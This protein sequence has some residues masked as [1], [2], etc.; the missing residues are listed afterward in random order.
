MNR[1]ILVVMLVGV[2]VMGMCLHLRARTGVGIIV[3]EPTGL[4]IKIGHFPVIGIAW[5]WDDY[6]HLHIDYWLKSARLDRSL[7]WFFG[8]GAK[9][10][11]H[12]KNQGD[13]G[14]VGLGLRVPLGLSY[15]FSRRFEVFGEVAPG[16]KLI[17]G[18]EFDIDGGIGIRF[19]F[20]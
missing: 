11:V 9:V 17:P 6:F 19:Y 18:T 7:Y 3:G 15:F 20:K 1:N 14:D 12:Q 5:S 10:S 2:L 16:M 4:S 8:F 13:D